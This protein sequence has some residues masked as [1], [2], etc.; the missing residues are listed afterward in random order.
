[1]QWHRWQWLKR[2]MRVEWDCKL[3]VFS[4]ERKKAIILVVKGELLSLSQ[5]VAAKVCHLESW[6]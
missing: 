5:Q 2:P 1:M 3:P 4:K 6:H